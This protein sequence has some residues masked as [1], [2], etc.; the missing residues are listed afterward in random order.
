LKPVTPVPPNDSKRKPAYY[1][2]DD[3]ERNVERETLN[4]FVDDL[5]GNKSPD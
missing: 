2:S 3:P 5:A 4:Y 1:R